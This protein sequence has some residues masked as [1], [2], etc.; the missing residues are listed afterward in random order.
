MQSQGNVALKRLQADL[1]EIKYDPLPNIAASPL[2]DDLFEW[3][4][5]LRG[6]IDSPIRNGVWHLIL[7]F[8]PTYPQSPPTVDLMTLLPHP[9][10]FA[11]LHGKKN[12]VCLD[13]LEEGVFVKEE[14]KNMQYTGWSSAYSIH[15]ILVQLQS[16]L[17]DDEMHYAS[18]KVTLA[19]AIKAANAFKCHS[20]SHNIDGKIWPAFPTLEELSIKKTCF[21][22]FNY[23]KTY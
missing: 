23:I 1:K 20:C 5:N 18:Y 22:S 6:P 16:F 13:L 21:S 10:V 15:S 11:N 3:H 17:F 19:D 9:F 8:K 2:N 12:W 14:D 7:K 4:I